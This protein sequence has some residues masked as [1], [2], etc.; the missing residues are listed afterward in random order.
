MVAALDFA[1]KALSGFMPKRN[2][3]IKNM[4]RGL[5]VRKGRILYFFVGFLRL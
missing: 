4:I 5:R 1:E 3:L 2:R